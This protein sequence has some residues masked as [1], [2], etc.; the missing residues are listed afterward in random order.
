MKTKS[1]H[2]WLPSCEADLHDQSNRLYFKYQ[3]WRLGIDSGDLFHG[4]VIKL[5]QRNYVVKTR[6][7]LFGLFGRVALTTMR[8]LGRKQ[9]VREKLFSTPMPTRGRPLPATTIDSV[10]VKGPS[11]AEQLAFSDEIACITQAVAS[12]PSLTNFLRDIASLCEK[13]ERASNANLAR[14]SGRNYKEVSNLREKLRSVA[15]K[16]REDNPGR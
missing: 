3:G 14:L 6:D 8:D 7:E 4:V 9:S 13:G 10:P 2:Q 16:V 11:P 5:L 12:D 15:L 1:F